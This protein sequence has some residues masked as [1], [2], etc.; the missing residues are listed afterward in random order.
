MFKIKCLSCHEEHPNWIGIDATSKR[1]LSGSRG[2][3]NFVWRCT[4]CKRESSIG[5]S[6]FDI[7]GTLD[8]RS[9][10]RLACAWATDVDEGSGALKR[11]KAALTLED[12]EVHK[13]APLV[14]FECRGCEILQFDP[15]VCRLDVV[16]GRAIPL[17][18]SSKGQLAV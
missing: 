6:L 17:K 13:F 15:K 2:E 7:R 16:S 3:A 10:N 9:A 8:T 1:P 4:L 12:S 14:V 11:D 5:L 18:Q